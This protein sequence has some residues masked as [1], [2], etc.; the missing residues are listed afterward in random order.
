VQQQEHGECCDRLAPDLKS[1]GSRSV[2]CS[3][4]SRCSLPSGR[5]RTSARAP[6]SPS[7][8]WFMAFSSLS[9][10]Q[11]VSRDSPLRL[12]CHQDLLACAT[13]RARCRLRRVCTLALHCAE[14][15]DYGAL[16]DTLVFFPSEQRSPQTP[17]EDF[18]RCIRK[19]RPDSSDVVCSTQLYMSTANYRSNLQQARGR[20]LQPCS[21]CHDATSVLPI[22]TVVTNVRHSKSSMWH[23]SVVNPPDLRLLLAMNRAPRHC[24]G[25][26]RFR[27][28]A[29]WRC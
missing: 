17:V 14:N 29:I 8:Q 12:T 6:A 15:A 5:A 26:Q 4:C 11:M 1:Q 24:T 18:R 9:S 3:P 10:P 2:S 25:G 13:S 27:R 19:G 7:L 28:G 21:T 16:S 23:S 22:V 20:I